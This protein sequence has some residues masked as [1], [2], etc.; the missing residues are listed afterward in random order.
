M[1]AGLA[2]L[3]SLVAYLFFLATFVYAIAFVGNFLVPKTIDSGE[4]GDLMTSL[5]INTGLLGV[6]AVQHSVM[7]RP[8]FKRM[9]TKI[10]PKEIERSTYVLFASAALALL[11]WQWRPMPQTVWSVTDPMLATAITILMWTGWAILLLSTYLISHFHLFGL[12]QGMTRLLKI[13]EKPA[14]FATPLFYKWV[15]HPLYLGFIIA[16]WSAPHMTVGHLFFAIACTA[17]I[18]IGIFFEERD[19][20]NEFGERYLAY[21]RNV[22]MIVPRLTPAKEKRV[23]G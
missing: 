12:T 18:F 20:T 9:W 16:F 14:N 21:R 3:Y 4:P 8:A 15:R 17:Y 6:F 7:A 11:L 19:L 2:A 23:G 5:L 1:R 10:V 13:T 22:G